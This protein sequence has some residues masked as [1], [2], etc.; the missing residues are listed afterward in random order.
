MTGKPSRTVR[1]GVVGKVFDYVEQLAGGSPYLSSVLRS[2]RAIRVNIVIM[3]AFVCLRQMVSENKKFA[4]KLRELE[5][6]VGGHDEAIDNLFDA[7]RRLMEQPE[8]T[9]LRIGF[10]PKSD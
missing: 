2:E 7:I 4:E 3:R 8:E 10:K 6:R 5:K 9:L 1:R